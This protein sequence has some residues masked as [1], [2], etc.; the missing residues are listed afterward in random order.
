MYYPGWKVNCK[1][2]PMKDIVK[3]KALKKYGKINLPE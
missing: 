3:E 2:R 1:N